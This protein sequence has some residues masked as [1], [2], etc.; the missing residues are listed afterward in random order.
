MSMRKVGPIYIGK[1]NGDIRSFQWQSSNC[2]E[3]A[4][5]KH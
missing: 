3:R 5:Q 4:D 2:S 1:F